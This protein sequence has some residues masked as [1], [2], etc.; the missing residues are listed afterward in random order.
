MTLIH[1]SDRGL[2]SGS[3]AGVPAEGT[4]AAGDS[5]PVAAAVAGDSHPA[6]GCSPVDS[7]AGTH[8]Q[9]ST[10]MPAVGLFC[11]RTAAFTQCGASAMLTACTNA[12]RRGLREHTVCI[13]FHSTN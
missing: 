6:A 2:R 12:T 1:G 9:T 4:R 13:H 10:A 3:S 5:S 8:W 11:L 7:P